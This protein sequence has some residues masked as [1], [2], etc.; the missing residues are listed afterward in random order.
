MNAVDN[1]GKNEISK[2]K[3]ID[4]KNEYTKS[5]RVTR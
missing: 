2:N 3:S 5:N 1:Q 4:N